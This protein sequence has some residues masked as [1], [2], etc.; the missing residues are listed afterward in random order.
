[1]T[2]IQNYLS[3][4]NLDSILTTFFN[5]AL[6]ILLLYLVF[7]VTKKLVRASVRKLLLPSLKLARQDQDRQK[8][9][10]RLVENILNYALYFILIYWILSILGLPVS[11][12][13]AGA[14]IAGVAIGLGAQGFLSDLVNGFFILVEHQFDVG[15]V[16][17]LTNGPIT[18]GGTI[19]SVGIRTTQVR[20]ADGTLH[21]IPNRNILVV[22]NKSR[23]DMRAQIDLPLSPR[24]DLEKVSQVIGAVNEKYLPDYPAIK[25]CQVLGAQASP[26]GQFSYRIHLT[27]ENGQQ[28]YIYHTF[29]GLYQEALVQAGIE[30]SQMRIIA[31]NGE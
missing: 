7:F 25:G 3:Q 19:V 17:C 28:N 2:F 20:D 15:D 27:V 30:L 24:A 4:F 13:L 8:T 31:G 14:G 11:S 26:S 6:S 1:M 18:I 23:G 16:V 22:S 12:L 21:F 10:M 29:Y 5:K 9:I